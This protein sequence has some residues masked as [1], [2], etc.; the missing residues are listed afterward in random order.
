MLQMFLMKIKCL[1][2][3]KSV[4]GKRKIGSYVRNQNKDIVNSDG[5][6]NNFDMLLYTVKSLHGYNRP[7][8]SVIL[9]T[10]INLGD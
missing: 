3:V 9:E 1:L 5:Y 4:N 6:N 2:P 10:P 7:I 8:T